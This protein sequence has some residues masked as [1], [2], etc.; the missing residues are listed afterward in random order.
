MNLVVD[1]CSREAAEYAALNWHY[2]RKMPYGRLSTFGVWYNSDFFGVIIFGQA[3]ARESAKKYNMLQSQICE[4]CRVAIKNG[5][6]FQVSQA[7]SASI[8]L[9]KRDNPGLHIIESYCDPALNHQG[10]IYK[11]MNFYLIGESA[12]NPIYVDKD[13]GERIS[14]RNVTRKYPPEII[15]SKFVKVRQ[16]AKLLF[17][18]PLSHSGRRAIQKVV[19]PPDA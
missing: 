15:R 17:A 19:K 11:A 5:H 3:S 10:T 7:V 16:E 4:L 1:Y 9:L 18:Y 14:H 8:K 13:S 2:A 12:R 6:Q